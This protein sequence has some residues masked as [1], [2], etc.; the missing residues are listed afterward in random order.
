MDIEVIK[1]PPKENWKELLKRSVLDKAELDDVVSAILDD[2]KANGDAALRKYS[3]KF[4][5]VALESFLVTKEEFLE[6][7]ELTDK[8]LKEAMSQAKRNLSIFHN[9]FFNNC[10]YG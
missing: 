2:V 3:E 4:D 7:E 10:T 8:T 5:G 6:A 9:R 1:Y